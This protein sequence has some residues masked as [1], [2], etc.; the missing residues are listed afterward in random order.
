[1]KKDLQPFR[2]KHPIV[3]HLNQVVSRVT[4]L[5]GKRPNA[6]PITVLT[7]HFFRRQRAAGGAGDVLVVVT[8]EPDATDVYYKVKRV[9]MAQPTGDEFWCFPLTDNLH[10]GQPVFD[11]AHVF[12]KDDMFWAQKV[13]LSGGATVWYTA[14]ALSYVGP[15]GSIRYNTVNHRMMAVFAAPE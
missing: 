10:L 2:G 7:P 4:H 13:T 3:K 9:V 11:F 14:E 6:L 12:C 15:Q 1:M 5:E 8:T